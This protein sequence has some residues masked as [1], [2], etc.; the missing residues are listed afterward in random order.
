MRLRPKRSLL[1]RG[2]GASAAGLALGR[3]IFDRRTPWYAKLLAGGVLLYLVSPVDLLPD[4]V[5]FLGQLDDLL[6]V[7][8]GLWLARSMIPPHVLEDAAAANRSTRR[9]R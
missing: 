1:Q 4:A 7:P 3:A 9:R 6:I 5:P 2:A 8:M